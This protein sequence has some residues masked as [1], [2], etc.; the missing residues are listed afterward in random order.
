MFWI[1]MIVFGLSVL[2]VKLGAVSVWMSI[3][4]SGLKVALLVIGCLVLAL[5]SRSIAGSKN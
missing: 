3:Y 1:S 4:S 2:L 5:V